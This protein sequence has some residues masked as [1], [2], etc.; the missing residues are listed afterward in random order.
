MCLLLSTASWAQSSPANQDL[1]NRFLEKNKEVAIEYFNENGK[2]HESLQ[3]CLDQSALCSEVSVNTQLNGELVELSFSQ[4]SLVEFLNQRYLEYRMLVGVAYYPVIINSIAIG[5]GKMSITPIDKS[6]FLYFE[7]QTEA[8]KEELELIKEIYEQEEK[9]IN[10]HNIWL[11][12]IP[13]SEAQVKNSDMMKFLKMQI[14]T[15]IQKYPF[16][17]HLHHPSA[18]KEDFSKSINK[19]IESYVSAKNHVEKLQGDDRFEILGFVS[20]FEETLG[21]FSEVEQEELI[22]HFEYIKENNTFWKRVADI[23]FNWYTIGMVACYTTSIFAP[24]VA[25]L[26]G[27]VGLG[28]AIPGIYGLVKQTNR[29]IQFYQTGHYDSGVFGKYI[30]SNIVAGVMYSIWLSGAVPGFTRNI[31]KVKSATVA[32]VRKIRID[33]RRILTVNKDVLLKEFEIIRSYVV[34]YSKEMGLEVGSD[35][36]AGIAGKT[37]SLIPAVSVAFS[38]TSQKLSTSSMNGLFKFS[39]LLSVTQRAVQ[40][41]M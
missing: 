14:A 27:A 36:L 25:V 12:E 26:C 18:N 8:G 24:P 41:G 32:V 39:D 20:V 6:G 17:V 28:F 1:L 7:N 34:Y 35:Q 30:L 23:V 16:F 11:S 10:Q 3:Y 22:G 21:S 5:R 19:T 13:V 37:N 31:V 40:H 38:R 29:L 2:N 15:Y 4:D 9:K 33:G